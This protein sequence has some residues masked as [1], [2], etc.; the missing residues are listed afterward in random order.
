MEVNIVPGCD[1]RAVQRGWLIMPSA[2]R[3]LDFFVDAVADRLNNLGLD[4]IALGID[5]YL[6]HHIASQVTRQLS[7]IH[8]RI[9]IHSWVSDVDLMAG[10][11]AVDHGAERRAGAR[12]VVASFRIGDL[13]RRLG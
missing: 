11:R 1:G 2:Q 3:G 9:G 4:H 8:G 10:N 7:P 5:R 6:N 13:R 12:I